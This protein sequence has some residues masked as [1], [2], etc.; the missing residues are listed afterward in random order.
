MERLI[1]LEIWQTKP[2]FL[3]KI[4]LI[5]ILQIAHLRTED[6]IQNGPEMAFF[7]TTLRKSFFTHI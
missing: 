5:H 2:A 3:I 6:F 7:L 1:I 4:L